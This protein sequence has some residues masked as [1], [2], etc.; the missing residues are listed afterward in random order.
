[1]DQKPLPTPEPGVFPIPGPCYYLTGPDA[2]VQLKETLS[3]AP[4][5]E[6]AK[7]ALDEFVIKFPDVAR[8]MKWQTGDVEKALSQI[9]PA[10]EQRTAWNGRMQALSIKHQK[11][12]ER[13]TNVVMQRNAL[14]FNIQGTLTGRVS[15]SASN[16]TEEP[17]IRGCTRAEL[18]E[19]Y[20]VF[21][22]EVRLVQRDLGLFKKKPTKPTVCWP[23]RMW[24][25]L[26]GWKRPAKP[27][28]KIL[29]NEE[30]HR[31]ADRIF[32]RYL[33][34][35]PYIIRTFWGGSVAFITKDVGGMQMW[36]CSSFGTCSNKSLQYGLRVGTLTNSP[37]ASLAM[38]RLSYPGLFD[39]TVVPRTFDEGLW[40][41]NKRCS[42]TPQ[43]DQKLMFNKKGESWWWQVVEGNYWAVF[44]GNRRIW[45][46]SRDVQPLTPRDAMIGLRLH[47][48]RMLPIETFKGFKGKL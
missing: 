28:R 17:R 3:K 27:G 30:L 8:W 38:F 10:P 46:I 35:A 41:W 24:R 40:W 47:D 43:G 2:F 9:E 7:K 26:T 20:D 14:N 25:K 37:E 1:M 29:D 22:R 4:T 16:V 13:A 33:T 18:A 42:L 48:P 21:L 45:P 36:Y 44:K 34:D 19:R 39:G 15:G 6:E 31:W 23:I 32:K 12:I 11:S 5:D